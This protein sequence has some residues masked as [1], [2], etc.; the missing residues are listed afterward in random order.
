MRE[1]E[2]GFNNHKLKRNVTLEKP[3]LCIKKQSRTSFNNSWPWH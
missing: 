2:Y 1:G 3:V